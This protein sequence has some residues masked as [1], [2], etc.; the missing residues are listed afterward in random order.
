[1]R[2]VLLVPMGWRGDERVGE[3]K[4]EGGEQRRRGF[5]CEIAFTDLGRNTS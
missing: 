1:M 2:G 3:Y 4:G 5:A